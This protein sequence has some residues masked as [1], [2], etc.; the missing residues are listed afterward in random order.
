M[1]IGSEHKRQGCMSAASLSCERQVVTTTYDRDA[2][3]SRPIIDQRKSVHEASE[4]WPRMM[5]Q[6]NTSNQGKTMWSL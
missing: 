4:V 3:I 5:R 2:A 1:E 6:P